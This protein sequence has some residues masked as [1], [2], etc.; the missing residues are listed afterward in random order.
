MDV[1]EVLKQLVAGGCLVRLGFGALY[2]VAIAHYDPDANMLTWVSCFPEHQ[3]HV[4]TVIVTGVQV[5]HG[6]DIRFTTGVSD[7]NLYFAPA[8]E[9]PELDLAAWRVQYI[10]WKR[11]LRYNRQLFDDFISNCLS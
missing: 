3:G 9:W 10:G 6:R 11:W 2:P 7:E 1:Q 8:A 5:F 4:H